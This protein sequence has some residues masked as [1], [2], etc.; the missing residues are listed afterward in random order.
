M[1]DYKKPFISSRLRALS[2]SAL[3]IS[4][5]LISCRTTDT[6]FQEPADGKSVFVTALVL[7]TFGLLRV[8]Y[9]VP[10]LDS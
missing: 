1:S 3:T 5:W 4:L 2:V 8:A 10:R 9:L 6:V 7:D